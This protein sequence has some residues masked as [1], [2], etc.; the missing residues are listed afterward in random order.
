MKCNHS[1]RKFAVIAAF[2]CASFV[3]T[4]ANAGNELKNG[5][6]DQIGRLLALGAFNVGRVVLGYQPGYQP[7][8]RP[9]YRRP[10]YRNYYRARGPYSHCNYSD[11]AVMIFCIES[12][13]NQSYLRYR[14]PW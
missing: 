13:A 9:D 7:G 12:A 4:P 3:A 6:E 1:I 10:Y 11:P 14:Y 8:Y 2:T 5:F